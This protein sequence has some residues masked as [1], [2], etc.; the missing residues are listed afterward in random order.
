MTATVSYTSGAPVE[1]EANLSLNKNH[2]AIKALVA[3]F[4][5]RAVSDTDLACNK[6]RFTVDGVDNFP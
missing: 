6:G 5:P 2:L 3:V 4:T 1:L